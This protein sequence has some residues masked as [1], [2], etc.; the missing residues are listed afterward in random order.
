MLYD[1]IGISPPILSSVQPIQYPY[2]ILH[3]EKVQDVLAQ[4]EIN[5]LRKWYE[6]QQ[7][8]GQFSSLV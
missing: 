6:R 5:R 4:K 1:Q 3:Y 2:R 8:K 7:K